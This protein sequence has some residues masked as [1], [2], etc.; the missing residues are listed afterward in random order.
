MT[1]FSEIIIEKK[2]SFNGSTV[3]DIEVDGVDDFPWGV[4]NHLAFY[5]SVANESN[6]LDF[7]NLSEIILGNNGNK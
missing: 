6:F 4:F 3:K 1:I 5:Q 7:G 2:L